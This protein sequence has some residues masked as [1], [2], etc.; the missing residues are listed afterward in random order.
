MKNPT[1]IQNIA[2]ATID[3]EAK[4]VHALASYIDGQFAEVVN[5]ILNM[6]GRLIVSGLVLLA[7]M[8]TARRVI[9]STAA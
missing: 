1:E 2:K 5:C 9:T 7:L 8:S 6:Q 4:A 3:N